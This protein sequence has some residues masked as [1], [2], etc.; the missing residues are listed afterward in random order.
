MQTLKPLSLTTAPRLN[1]NPNLRKMSIPGRFKLT[2]YPEYSISTPR[3][4]DNSYNLWYSGGSLEKFAGGRVKIMSGPLDGKSPTGHPSILLFG[5]SHREGW[6]SVSSP[7]CIRLV[8]SY[9]RHRTG[10][11]RPT[12]TKGG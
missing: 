2:H 8:E 11:E 7:R 1:P 10:L 12:E 4:I 9:I 6:P 3:T 5:K